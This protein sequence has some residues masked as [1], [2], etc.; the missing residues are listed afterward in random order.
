MNSR[1]CSLQNKDEEIGFLVFS[2]DISD[3][4]K[5]EEPLGGFFLGAIRRVPTVRVRAEQNCLSRQW[6]NSHEKGES[7]A[8]DRDWKRIALRVALSNSCHSCV[9]LLI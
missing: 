1:I 9:H 3:F 7:S 8:M 6:R 2:S 5:I 4:L